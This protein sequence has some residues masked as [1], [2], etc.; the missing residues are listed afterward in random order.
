[1]MLGGQEEIVA[2]LP[3]YTDAPWGVRLC[4]HSLTRIIGYYLMVQIIF[5]K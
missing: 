2:K 1:M 3:F 4:Q 5:D